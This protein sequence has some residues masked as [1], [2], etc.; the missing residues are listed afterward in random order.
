MPDFNKSLFE[1]AQSGPLV[2]AHRGVSGANIPCNTMAAFRAALSQGAD[3]IELD[4]SK[5]R[6]G[7]FYVFHPGM[8]KP[9]LGFPMLLSKLSSKTINR[10]RFV[11]QDDNPT[12]CRINT[13]EEVLSFLK[14]KC[15]INIDKF[16]ID[17][18][19]ISEIIRKTGVEK[20][21]IVKT[22]TKEKYLNQVEKYAPDFMFMPIVSKE[23][24]ITDELVK[25]GINCIGA[26][27][28]FTTEEQK[29]CSEEYIE[30]MHSKKMIVWA[31]SI[32]YNYKSVLSAGHTDDI[33]VQG[34]EDRGWGWLIDRGF[35]IIQTDWC[36]M[37]KNYIRKR[38][39]R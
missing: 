37:L 26:E 35:D 11:N 6:D 17:I 33:A 3:I 32:V 8:E 1:N 9:H 14:G 21:V 2:C 39:E 23:D 5:S 29:V 7:V 12:V 25:K 19:G 16:W 18:P 10:L 4:V 30:Y 27:V 20:Q 24:N 28:L 36:L 38:E 15:Y 22:D 13:L 31:N 34:E